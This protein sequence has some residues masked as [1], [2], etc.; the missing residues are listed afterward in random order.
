MTLR[1]NKEVISQG[2]KEFNGLLD[3]QV[4]LT[5]PS[6]YSFKCWQVVEGREERMVRNWEVDLIETREIIQVK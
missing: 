6:M 2:V 5:T 4:S 1:D 3:Q